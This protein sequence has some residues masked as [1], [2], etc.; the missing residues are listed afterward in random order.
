MVGTVTRRAARGAVPDSA[1]RREVVS[2]LD[3]RVVP[4]CWSFVR[5]CSTQTGPAPTDGASTGVELVGSGVTAGSAAGAVAV[6]GA[7]AGSAATGGG[8]DAGGG[9]V[10]GGAAG[11]GGGWGALRGGSKASGST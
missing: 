6:A 8:T 2:T 11:A 1:A 3:V 4:L 10:A 5:F 7:G 9:A